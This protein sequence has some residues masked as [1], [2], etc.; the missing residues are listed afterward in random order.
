MNLLFLHERFGA[1]AGAEAN[2]LATAMELKARG[3]RVGLVHGPPTGRGEQDW[4]QTFESRYPWIP[5]RPGEA[6][7]RAIDDFKPDVIYVHKSS[8]LK[9][10]EVLVDS[11]VP[12]IRMVHDHDLYCM[13]S[14]KYNYFSRAICTRAASPYCVFPCG[15]SIQR[16]RQGILPVQW[17]SYFAKK[18]ELRLNRQFH[19][20]IVATHYMKDELLR[21]GFDSKQ[22]EVHPPVPHIPDCSPSSSFGERNLLLYVGQVIRGKGV[23]VLL[24]SLARVPLPFECLILGDGNHRTYCM[25][26]ARKLGLQDR[27]S[28]KGFVPQSELSKYYSECSLLLMSSVWPEP[29]GAVGLE[30]MRYGLPVVAFDAGGI[31]EW[32]ID[33]YNGFLVP[34]MDRTEYASKVQLLLENK[35]L[36]RRMGRNGHELLKKEYDFSKYISNLERMFVRVVWETQ[37][38]LR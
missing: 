35:E 19:R 6:V 31:R 38:Q 24:E 18:K 7:E 3:H 2:A 37:L 32:L 29:F 4:N 26:L 13:R 12:V 22:I 25:E 1:W 16:N 23:D 36:A 27:V 14:Y 30:G 10:L 20:L 33:G 9:V 8:D 34:W 5:Q 28:F 11:E 17:V 21:N 15:A